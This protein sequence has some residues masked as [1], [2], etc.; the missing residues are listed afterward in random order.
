MTTEMESH[1]MTNDQIEQEEGG[2]TSR[3]TGEMTRRWR[4]EA[5][6]RRGELSSRGGGQARTQ[7]R[8]FEPKGGDLNKAEIQAQP[9]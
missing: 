3:I 6:R 9:R 2:D 7:W 5:A 4:G 8:R 1:P